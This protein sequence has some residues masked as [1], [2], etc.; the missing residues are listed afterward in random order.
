MGVVVGLQRGCGWWVTTWVVVVGLVGPGLGCGCD[1][2]HFAGLLL[3][4]FACFV[5][6][7]GETKRKREKEMMKDKKIIFK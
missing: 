3:C 7:K 2:L 6:E 4:G 5:S 1:G